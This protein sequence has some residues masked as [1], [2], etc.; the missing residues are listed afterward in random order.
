MAYLF[1]VP[2]KDINFGSFL[3][4]TAPMHFCYPSKSNPFS[5][6]TLQVRDDREVLR[7]R[8]P[9]QALLGQ[10][11]PPARLRRRRPPL[12]R[13]QVLRVREK[14]WCSVYAVQVTGKKRSGPALTRDRLF[15]PS[16]IV[17]C[18][19]K[20]EMRAWDAQRDVNMQRDDV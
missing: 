19:L 9:P 7:H 16:F 5:P 2:K 4:K 3:L 8:A 14:G 11:V 18:V 10:K 1:V 20:G 6:L 17:Y 13:P 15:G 12:Q